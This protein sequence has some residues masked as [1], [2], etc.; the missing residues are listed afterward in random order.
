MNALV[1]QVAVAIGPLPMP[2]VVQTLARQWQHFDR[3]APQV[4]VDILRDIVISTCADRTARL[5]TQ[6]AGDFDVNILETDITLGDPQPVEQD[7][8]SVSGTVHNGG[9]DAAKSVV[10]SLF[11]GDPN[12]NGIFLESDY[13]ARI[14]A[15]GSALAE[16]T[17]FNH[18]FFGGGFEHCLFEVGIGA[19]I[20]LA[21]DDNDFITI[22]H[23]SL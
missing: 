2:I 9:S 22:K 16:F 17:F 19:R 13:L 15:S 4:V 10:V 6:T 21:A 12:T 18:A 1:A 5:V 3:T 14:S 7:E 11:A 20:V 23:L 8:V